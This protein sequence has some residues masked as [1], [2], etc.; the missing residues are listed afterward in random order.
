MTYSIVARDAETGELGVAVQTCMF[1]VGSIVPWAR[2]GV[3]AV[4]T[5]AIA[6]SAY[7]PWC[8]DAL[9]TARRRRMRWPRPNAR[10]RCRCSVRWGSSARTTLPRRRPVSCASITG[11]FRRRRVCCAGE[12]DER[13]RS[14]AGD[15]IGVYRFVRPARATLARRTDGRGGGRGC[16]RG[17]MSAALI[18]VDGSLPA[19]PGAGT[20]VDIRVD[21]S[22]DPLGDLG[23][24]ARRG[25]CVPRIQPRD[26]PTRRRRPDRRARNGRRRARAAPRRSEHALLA[27]GGLG[28]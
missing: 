9:A 16:A 11:P 8:L 14:V 6:E 20:V 18:V 10:I 2:A 5:Q 17:H 21:R 27:Q 24:A 15:G 7:G 1:A 4:A 26:R 12:H 25:R 19:Q 22:D 3:G 23:A 13:S 28:G